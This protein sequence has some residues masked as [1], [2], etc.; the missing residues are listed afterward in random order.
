MC[1][2][3]FS[4]WSFK[5]FPVETTQEI[6]CKD[7]PLVDGD[8]C[9][10]HNKSYHL[11][12]CMTSIRRDLHEI[13]WLARLI[14]A[15][16]NATDL[17]SGGSSS[18]ARR[19]ELESTG[20]KIC[21]DHS[22]LVK[23]RVIKP[24]IVNSSLLYINK[25]LRDRQTLAILL[26]WTPKFRWVSKQSLERA[27]CVVS[28]RLGRNGRCEGLQ[29]LQDHWLRPCHPSGR[30]KP[31]HPSSWHQHNDTHVRRPEASPRRNRRPGK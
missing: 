12:W 22:H 13:R 11:T 31:Y 4:N 27:H 10:Y 17:P 26:E 21:Q 3:L 7:D 23:S 8:T 1:L 2:Y 24:L 28:V 20:I 18:L 19:R 5:I 16:K 15:N 14:T 29:R 30:A 6:E 9:I 25:S